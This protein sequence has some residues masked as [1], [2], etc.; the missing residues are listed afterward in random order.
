MSKTK[1]LTAGL[2]LTFVLAIPVSAA[3]MRVQNAKAEEAVVA[4]DATED[5]TEKTSEYVKSRIEEMKEMKA[6]AKV[7]ATEAVVER[8]RAR[9]EAMIQR[10]VQRYEKVQT[11][12]RTAEGLTS[13]EKTAIEAKVT[14]QI[15]AMNTLRIQVQAADTAEELKNVM[16]QVKT[17]FKFSLGLMRQ[18][19]SG[20]FEDRLN[21]VL[22]KLTDVYTRLS[23][24]VALLPV[25]D[26]KTELSALLAEAQA[27]LSEA[28]V[29]IDADD[30]T[31]AKEDLLA[32]R[33]NL[34]L[35]AEALTNDTAE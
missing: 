35:V 2:M 1:W 7:T 10:A 12:V 33:D 18:T 32:A 27:S 24:K 9:V 17:R 4:T 20:V 3:Q 13:E 25:G 30:L 5:V 34:H 31:S 29:N 6:A 16:T 14:A 26:G 28:K 8:V 21:V 15:E 11:Q 22:T 23:E 19:V